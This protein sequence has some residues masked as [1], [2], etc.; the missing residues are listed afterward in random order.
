MFCGKVANKDLNRAHKRALRTLNNDYSSS[1]E[2]LL[3]K[4][5]ECKIHFKNL[6]QLM[7]EAYKCIK[8]EPTSFM[9]NMFHEKS[10]QYDLRSKN[11]LILPQA[12]TI[13]Y[14]NDSLIFRGSISWNYLQNDIKS[15]TPF[16]SFKKCI[17]SWSAE[18]C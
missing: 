16:C 14:G 6:Q 11:L 3:R 5:N 15:K 12:N 18:G 7:L 2:E 4:L 8:K 9:W 10:S 1:F 17:K 13:R